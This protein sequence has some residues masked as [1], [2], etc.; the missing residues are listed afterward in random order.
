MISAFS[1]AKTVIDCDQSSRKY[2]NLFLNSQGIKSKVN[3]HNEKAHFRI[4]S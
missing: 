1:S 3:L 4:K 2:N